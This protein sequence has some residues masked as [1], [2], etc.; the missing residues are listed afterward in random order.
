[1]YYY[2]YF[3]HFLNL[4]SFKHY[5]NIDNIDIINDS[6]KS[7]DVWSISRWSYHEYKGEKKFTLSYNYYTKNYEFNGKRYL[8]YDDVIKD[9]L[10]I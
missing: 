6:N 3:L 10:N 9:A 8:L 7:V 2:P 4:L 5:N 1:M